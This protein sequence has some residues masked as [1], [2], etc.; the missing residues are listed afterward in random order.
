MSRRSAAER[1]PVEA[2][3]LK[4]PALLIDGDDQLVDVRDELVALRFPQSIRTLLQQL[5]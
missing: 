5:H 1:L 2:D 4:V 3:Y